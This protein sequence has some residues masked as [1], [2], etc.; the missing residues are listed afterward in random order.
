VS[1]H[2]LIDLVVYQTEA[3]EFT[4]QRNLLIRKHSYSI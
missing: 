3:L 1:L 4:Q 2:T